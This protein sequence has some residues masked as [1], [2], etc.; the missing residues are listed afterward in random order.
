MLSD[1]DKLFVYLFSDETE[2]N[3]KF[4]AEF[5]RT[6]GKVEPPITKL[7]LV[8]EVWERI[9]PHRELVIG[10]LRIRTKI[11]NSSNEPYS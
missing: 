8:K 5:I 4:K 7:D 11:K 6:A 3:A 9:L 10:G 1:Y 2:E